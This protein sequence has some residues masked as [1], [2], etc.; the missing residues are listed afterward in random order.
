MSSPSATLPTSEPPVTP[1]QARIDKL[2]YRLKKHHKILELG[3]SYNPAVSRADGW[4]SFSMDHATAEEL[5]V[6]YANDAAAEYGKR[7]QEVD[8]VWRGGPLEDAIPPEHLG[9]F[10]AFVA[11]HVIEHTPDL[12]AFFQSVARI[13]RPMGLLTLA[14]PDKRFCFD[15]FQNPT[16]TSDALQAYYEKRTRHSRRTFFNCVAYQ[17]KMNGAL[18]IAQTAVTE[19]E[20]CN[21]LTPRT[22]YEL[23]LAHD[24]SVDAPY[25]DAHSWYFTPASF[26]LI[27]LEL[28]AM[29]LIEFQEVYS[30]PASGNEFIITLQ[31]DPAVKSENVQEKRTE[32][33]K[34]MLLDIREQTDY[35]LETVEAKN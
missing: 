8:F 22:L 7:I 17:A 5:R 3:P 33:L 13:V 10:D 2:L 4:N 34:Q 1:P 35:M 18:S 9:T 29:G 14:V 27:C 31:K 32:L 24:D 6:K 15:Y 26:R 25:V 20:L 19:I 12:V 23:Y 16:R 28:R 21:Q 30:F 11:S